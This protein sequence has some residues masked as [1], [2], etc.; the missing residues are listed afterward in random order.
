MSTALSG[1]LGYPGSASQCLRRW[2]SASGS[3]VR[4]RERCRAGAA[5]RPRPAPQRPGSRATDGRPAGRWRASSRTSR[6]GTS[7][8]S[9]CSTSGSGEA[10]RGRRPSRT[11]A[12]STGST[13]RRSR[14]AWPFRRVSRP[15]S[16]CRSPRRS[17]GGSPAVSDAIIEANARAGPVAQLAAGRAPP[18]APGR[19]RRS[20]SAG[21]GLGPGPGAAQRGGDG[22]GPAPS[23]ASA[24]QAPKK[25]Q[26]P[27]DPTEKG[28]MSTTLKRVCGAYV[29]TGE[30][31][32]L[33][34]RRRRA[35][36]SLEDPR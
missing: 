35:G 6:S 4:G 1:A 28:L 5:S 9:C 3:L 31:G 18:R 27:W 12:T 8:S 15:T 20:A 14:S 29:L 2:A 25:G 17:I 23:P 26:P 21:P 32:G 34:C 33:M 13:M 16:R 7:A 36:R 30:R 22:H 24:R 10:P 11:R 19:D